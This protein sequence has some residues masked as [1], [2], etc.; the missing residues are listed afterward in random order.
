[1]FA[2]RTKPFSLPT[3]KKIVQLNFYNPGEMFL[4]ICHKRVVDISNSVWTQLTNNEQI[5]FVPTSESII[6]PSMYK[7]PVDI[8]LSGT[9]KLRISANC[10]CFGKSALFQTH[11]IL[12]VDNPGYET[13]FMS[14]V[15]L[16]YDCCEE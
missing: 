1:M 9:G 16:E 3:N 11:S 13:D 15:H 5:Y 14:K 12:N 4:T 6:T 10:K 7:P 2:N 8:I